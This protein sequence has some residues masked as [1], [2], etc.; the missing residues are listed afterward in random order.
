MLEFVQCGRDISGHGEVDGAGQ[1]VPLQCDAAVERA[2][3]VGGAF[4]E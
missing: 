1:I 2:I 3:P 4:V